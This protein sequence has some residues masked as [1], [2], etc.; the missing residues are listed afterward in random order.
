MLQRCTEASGGPFA[1]WS[2]W[3][4]ERKIEFQDYVDTTFAAGDWTYSRGN[5]AWMRV[6]ASRI[7]AHMARDLRPVSISFGRTRRDLVE[8]LSPDSSPLP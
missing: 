2:S 7:E 6:P 5:A 3:L 8:P 4:T 1:G